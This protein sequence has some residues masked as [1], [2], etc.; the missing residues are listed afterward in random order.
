MLKN[1]RYSDLTFGSIWSPIGRKRDLFGLF[2]WEASL[3]LVLEAELSFLS[4]SVELFLIEAKLAMPESACGN[5][6][7]IPEVIPDNMHVL[8]KRDF[9]DFI[10]WKNSLRSPKKAFLSEALTFFTCSSAA[11]LS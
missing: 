6:N 10:K 9:S 1:L 7:V 11:F 3:P 8:T 4:A 5:K 2:S